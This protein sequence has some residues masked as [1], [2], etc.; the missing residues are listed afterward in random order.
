MLNRDQHGSGLGIFARTGLAKGQNLELCPY[1]PTKLNQSSSPRLGVGRIESYIKRDDIGLVYIGGPASLINGGCHSC[2]NVDLHLG[3]DR[4]NQFPHCLNEIITDS[5]LL[6]EYGQDYRVD[7]FCAECTNA[8]S[9]NSREPDPRAHAVSHVPVLE[10]FKGE[11]FIPLST[12]DVV[13]ALHAE[14]A[15]YRK[16]TE[17]TKECK[18]PKQ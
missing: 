18:E 2:A 3:F 11:G 13:A 4:R 10:E 16:L 8:L 15:F 5:Q 6:L 12:S 9:T 1:I 7:I 14:A 17:E